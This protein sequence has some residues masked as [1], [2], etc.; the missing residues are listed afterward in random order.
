MAFLVQRI[1]V[2]GKNLK[3]RMQSL[4]NSS[5]TLK[6]TAPKFKNIKKVKVFGKFGKV[7]AQEFFCLYKGR[8]ST[9]KFASMLKVGTSSN[10]R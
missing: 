5:L 1:T 3:K 2:N 6:I 10:K 9:C 7:F 8:L 4:N